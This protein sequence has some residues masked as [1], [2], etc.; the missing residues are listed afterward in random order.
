MRSESHDIIVIGSGIAGLSFALHCSAFFPLRKI[1][2][3]SKAL[4]NESN[5]S[6]AQGGIAAV[7]NHLEDSYEQHIK[8]TLQAGD[9]LCDKRIV[10]MVVQKAPEEMRQL[11]QWGVNFDGNGNQPDLGKEGGHS[12]NRILHCRDHTGA[13]IIEVL[14]RRC[15][16]AANIELRK[17]HF[18]LELLKNNDLGMACT[19]AMVCSDDGVYAI[20][21]HYTMLATGGS[22]QVYSYTSNPEIAT[23][24]GFSLA[25]EIGTQLKNMAFVQFHPTVFYSPNEPNPFLISEA[26][27]GYGAVLRNHRGEEFVYKYDSRG[28]LATRDVV[29]R[30]IYNEIQESGE[31]H[32][33]LDFRHF[34]TNDFAL[35]FPTIAAYLINKNVDVRTEM[36]PVKPAAHYFCGGVITNKFGKT[37]V[38]HLL[39]AGEC[40]CT[41][42]HGANR[43]ASNSLLEAL[44][45]AKN[46]AE[47]LKTNFEEL[48]FNHGGI[49]EINCSC[50]EMKYN[51]LKK[52]VQDIMDKSVGVI[53]TK[54][55]LISARAKLMNLK[56]LL[57]KSD[58][59]VKACELRIMVNVSLAVV[60]DSLQQTS[61]RGGFYR[62][63]LNEKSEVKE[64]L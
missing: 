51:G 13:S 6:C 9:G 3:L 47:N 28:S 14:L 2:V 20:N 55:R 29:A 18:V 10:E 61:N 59:S 53:R 24:D 42:L 27:R 50:S 49:P 64:T 60:E 22:G 19:G 17:N 36:V 26:V 45:F 48:Q 15:E 39:A 31:E 54:P 38:P 11:M 12:T 21:G 63:D 56:H 7:M 16:E 37:T 33:W 5:T 8:D 40:T 44:V 57:P 41:G 43:L 30:A 62:D 25:M 23:G 46:A 1:V 4:I 58:Y 52:N 34:D 32:V 35:K